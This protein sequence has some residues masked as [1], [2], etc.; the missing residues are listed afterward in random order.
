MNDSK[1]YFDFLNNLSEARGFPESISLFRGL[2]MRSYVDFHLLA[3]I[4]INF[5]LEIKKLDKYFSATDETAAEVLQKGLPRVVEHKK[6][7]FGLIPIIGWHDEI[8]I[9]IY[10]HCDQKP[11]DES[12]LRLVQK[13]IRSKYKLEEEAIMTCVSQTQFP[14]CIF[15]KN[16]KIIFASDSI[17]QLFQVPPAEFRKSGFKH[18]FDDESQSKL[19]NTIYLSNKLIEDGNTTVAPMFLEL[20][21]PDPK[22]QTLDIRLQAIFK[23]NSFAYYLM[24]FIDN[25]ET[26]QLSKAVDSIN[27]E[28]SKHWERM[29]FLFDHAS[30]SIIIHD[31]TGQ[32]VDANKTAL[33]TFGYLYQELIETSIFTLS[34]SLIRR[35]FN[36]S[37]KSDQGYKYEALFFTRHGQKIFA[38]VKTKQVSQGEN[39]NY[40]SFIR[41]ITIRKNAIEELGES[42]ARYRS[43]INTVPCG[44]TVIESGTFRYINTIGAG[45]LGFENP[46]TLIDAKIDEKLNTSN[47]K[48]IRTTITNHLQSDHRNYPVV[49]NLQ[50]ERKINVFLR[51]T[52]TEITYQQKPA[53]LI[54]AIDITNQK[55]TENVLRMAKLQ[56]EE[57][58]FIKSAF[59]VNISHELRTPLNA[60]NGF[61]QLLKAE[62]DLSV[63]LAK[64]YLDIIL[65][66]SKLLLDT[67]GNLLEVSEI[68]AGTVHLTLQ[69][70]NIG[71]FFEEIYQENQLLAKHVAFSLNRPEISENELLF[72]DP[73]RLKQIIQLLL[74]NAFK[75]TAKGYVELKYWLEGL[76][77]FVWIKDTGVGIEQSKLQ[78]V[79]RLFRQEEMNVDTRKYG[80]TGVGLYLV[81]RLIS[82]LHG[83]ISV[84]SEKGKGSTFTM[85]IPVSVNGSEIDINNPLPIDS[86]AINWPNKTILI[87]EDTYAN[88]IF[89]KE[90]FSELSPKVFVASSGQEGLEFLE[91]N[92]NTDLVFLDIQLPDISGFDVIRK[93]KQKY[94]VPVVAQT[95]YA[96]IADREKALKNGFDDYLAK[97]ISS[98]NLLQV[99]ANLILKN[100]TA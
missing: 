92:P 30:D 75:F 88:A 36:E 6:K 48:Q 1:S 33:E 81:K 100:S 60:I 65:E 27:Q 21:S 2:C 63:I 12:F 37:A 24:E 56:A 58:D 3:T 62:K 54:M 51:V 9:L 20:V 22:S 79:F 28:L 80:G 94:T 76:R 97:P 96:L 59:L 64:R 90:V 82:L 66:N 61:T 55:E 98:Q 29:V 99:A 57:E 43:L 89:I 44:L 8:E 15:D 42:E 52:G 7:W 25:T 69:P 68:H 77:L 70:C 19:L 47:L 35:K 39:K 86:Q 40:I 72:I 4:N 5:K 78:N 41:D 46:E 18:Y 93:I 67:V 83:N 13:A 95:A 49:V 53:V 26:K 74:N 34:P 50:N 10:L 84:V 14:L 73:V 91:R 45:I 11:F 16:E 71:N 85:S 23:N 17:E 32:I 87:I 38:E 31:Q